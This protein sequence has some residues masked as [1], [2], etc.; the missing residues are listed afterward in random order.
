MNN[1]ST[2]FHQVSAD[3]PLSEEEKKKALVHQLIIDNALNAALIGI[4][5]I[6]LA[7]ILLISAV[8]L[9]MLN[10][11]C[12]AYEVRFSRHSGKAVLLSL[13]GGLATATID[14][15]SG[16]I[17]YLSWLKLFGTVGIGLVGGAMTYAIGRIF[18]QHLEQGGTL[19][20]FN[21]QRSREAL[22]QMYEEGKKIINLKAQQPMPV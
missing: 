7:D 10:E 16:D 18:W 20:D 3:L 8:Q 9:K 6:P 11:L 22:V 15:F 4:I 2:Y 19:A 5:P 1:Q 12:L 17:V 13:I 14:R 21:H